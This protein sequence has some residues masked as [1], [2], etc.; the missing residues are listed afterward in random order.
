M[1]GS[2]YKHSL[3]P[4]L[5]EC[6]FV[7][8]QVPLSPRN[9]CF[10]S[11]LFAASPRWPI[12]PLVFLNQDIDFFIFFLK[13]ETQH[14]VFLSQRDMCHWLA[15]RVIHAHK[16]ANAVSP[17]VSRF[18]CLHI[19]NLTKYMCIYICSLNH[20]KLVMPYNIS[21][22]AQNDT[23]LF[24]PRGSLISPFTFYSLMTLPDCYCVDVSFFFTLMDFNAFPCSYWYRM[25][26]NLAPVGSPE[27]GWNDRC[28]L[29]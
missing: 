17:S 28:L 24:C 1:P 19:K 25:T 16:R 21:I 12:Q 22:C 5:C 4:L 18:I 8:Y 29:N 11:K 27:P 26:L 13:V 23:Q 2:Q 9:K 14:I 20:S 10:W 15:F 6:M 3:V 7:L